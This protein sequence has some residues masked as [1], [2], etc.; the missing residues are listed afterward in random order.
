MGN[1]T[2]TAS[3]CCCSVA[4][5]C[6]FSSVLWRQ[7]Y[8][9]TMALVTKPLKAL[10][11]R[12]VHEKLNSCNVNSGN[13]MSTILTTSN[14]NFNSKCNNC[15]SAWPRV[16]LSTNVMQHRLNIFR[17]ILKYSVYMWISQ[18]I[19]NISKNPLNISYLQQWADFETLRQTFSIILH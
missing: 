1:N 4:V 6:S 7:L 19:L 12:S 8:S 18:K 13:V 5:S 9:N 10:I 17:E 3:G 11:Y 14:N 2:L 16:A 15:Y